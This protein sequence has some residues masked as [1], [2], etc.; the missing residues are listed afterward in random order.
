MM[1]DWTDALYR[2]FVEPTP[3]RV[4]PW[5]KYREEFPDEYND[6]QRELEML[7]DDEY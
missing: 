6:D 1:E 4:S 2:L 5:E 3:R 7:E